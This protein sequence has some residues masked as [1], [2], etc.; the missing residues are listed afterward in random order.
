[1]KDPAFLADAKKRKMDLAPLTGA[2][3]QA[4]IDELMKTPKAILKQA[5]AVLKYTK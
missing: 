4:N 3:V 2:T 5:A 1:M